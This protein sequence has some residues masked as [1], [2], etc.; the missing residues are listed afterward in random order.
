MNAEEFSF[1]RGCSDAELK[2]IRQDAEAASRENLATVTA[3]LYLTLCA[4]ILVFVVLWKAYESSNWVEVLAWIAFV[5]IAAWSH[6]RWRRFE[7]E[8]RR[9]DACIQE[10]QRRASQ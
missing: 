6:F 3:G 2:S 4:P 8:K 5:A 9:R 1:L 10:L 7:Y